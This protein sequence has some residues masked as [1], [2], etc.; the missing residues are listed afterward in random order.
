MA[1]FFNG[2]ERRIMKAIRFLLALVFIIALGAC[3]T[4]QSKGLVGSWQK[5]NGT[6]TIVFSPDGKL[7]MVNGPA[8]LTTSYKIEDG[9][10]LQANLG[11]FG[12]GAIKFSLS[13]DTLTLTD[14]KGESSR[15]TRAKETKEMEKVKPPVQPETPK[16]S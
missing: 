1:K 14:A 5:E 8:T 9:E 10:K 3:T 13:Q 12:T 7:T 2:S 4:S 11:V 6:E 15:Y 16:A